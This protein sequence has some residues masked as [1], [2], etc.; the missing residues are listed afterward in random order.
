[1]IFEFNY[2]KV[3]IDVE[4]TKAFYENAEYI[5]SHCQCS[6]CRNF[7]KAANLIS[8]KATSIFNDMGIDMQKACEVY[9]ITENNNNTLY[10][11]GFYHLCGKLISSEQSNNRIDDNFEFIFTDEIDLLEDN[12]PEPVIQLEFYAT[13]P[14][15]LEEKMSY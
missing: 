8:E 3:E 5:T 9:G 6:G 7:E 11:G 14:W 1:M 2:H 13:V 12:F 10:Y 4:K 15:L